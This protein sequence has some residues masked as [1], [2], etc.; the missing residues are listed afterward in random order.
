[1]ASKELVS[2]LKQITSG[3][4][5]TTSNLAN[6]EMAFGLV[7][8]VA[9]LY[10][11][12]NGTIVDFSNFL[13][14]APVTSVN[15]KTGAVS[16]TKS[17]VDLGNVQ[18]VDNTDASTITKGFLDFQR[19]SSG[20]II[21]GE[22]INVGRDDSTGSFII[23]ANSPAIGCSIC[24]GSDTNNAGYHNSIYRGK[25]ITGY[26]N[27]GSIWN[28]ISSGDFDDLFV[29]DYFNL[30]YD[31]TYPIFRI[32][33]FD[34]FL[35]IGMN[36]TVIN[37]HVVIVSDHPLK[38]NYINSSGS[39]DNGFS[40]SDFISVDYLSISTKLNN[41]FNNHVYSTEE[42]LTSLT[43][44]TLSNCMINGLKGISTG[45]RSSICNLNLLSETEVYGHPVYSSSGYE[46]EHVWGQLPLFRLNPSKI[47]ISDYI[48]DR[49]WWLRNIA[50]STSYC[51]VSAYGTP[52][53][54]NVSNSYIGIR[55]RFILG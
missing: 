2:N 12:M 46:N 14:S 38:H 23:S 8:G 5:P 37:H 35:N 22:N 47:T 19:L 25:D 15:N 34:I 16:L 42:R 11:N 10:G 13:T 43:S 20:L 45:S 9:K 51:C 41:V 48:G 40:R 55:P 39:T 31:D 28:R 53:Y 36:G 24:S 30:A 3:Q 49:R 21:A 33:G 17:D 54:E 52:T 1:M 27:D 26:F 50:S 32:A 6:G 7:G 44:S 18:N 29:G 4:V